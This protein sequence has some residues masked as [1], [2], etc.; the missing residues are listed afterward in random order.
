MHYDIYTI[1]HYTLLEEMHNYEMLQIK[2]TYCNT[3][4]MFTLL[5]VS[6]TE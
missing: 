1:I 6:A 5:F 3:F 4:V 2:I